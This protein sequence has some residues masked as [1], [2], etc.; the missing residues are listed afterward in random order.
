MN[1]KNFST[2]LLTAALL[3][4]ALSFTPLA[5]AASSCSNGKCGGGPN[6]VEQMVTKVGEAKST[7]SSADLETAYDTVT[8]VND[9][10]AKLGVENTKKV[11][12][13][14]QELAK[15]VAERANTE[16]Q[17][18]LKDYEKGNYQAALTVY[19]RLAKLEGLPAAKRAKAEIKIEPGRVSWRTLRDTVKRQIASS[20]HVQARTTLSDL[21]SLSRRTG[22]SK[23]QVELAKEL[24]QS[25]DPR[26]EDAK[27]AVEKGQFDAAYAT[28]I[29]ISRI[30]DVRTSSAAARKV[31]AANAT[32][33]DMRQAQAEYDGQHRLQ[34]I[35]S[36]IAEIAHPSSREQELYRTTLDQIAQ[37]YG[38]TKAGEKA[39]RLLEQKSDQQARN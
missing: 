21:K 32:H 25:L 12:G 2:Q 6:A 3:G 31:L 30:S 1:M 37:T 22:Y 36:W 9:E 38:N 7:V 13:G 39:K 16:L 4:A 15:I 19:Q 20:E 14:I 26:I 23:D 27:D 33:P 34:D 11:K 29:E 35:Q 10:A 24:A 18:A 5:M 8:R 28:L 17:A